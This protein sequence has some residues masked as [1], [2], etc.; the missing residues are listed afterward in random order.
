[1][2][3]I[4]GIALGWS[5]STTGR[6]PDPSGAML[7]GKQEDRMALKPLELRELTP[8]ERDARECAI[9]KAKTVADNSVKVRPL[10]KKKK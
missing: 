2:V 5:G 3:K 4:T 6:A 10:K 9:K 1:V 7:S 8:E